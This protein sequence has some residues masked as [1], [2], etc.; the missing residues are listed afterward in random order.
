[1]KQD[2]ILRKITRLLFMGCVI[3]LPSISAMEMHIGLKT[4]LNMG[5]FIIQSTK[6]DTVPPD[7]MKISDIYSNANANQEF[8]A[9][10][11]AGISTQLF[12]SEQQSWFLELDMMYARRNH[13]FPVSYGQKTNLTQKIE[14]SYILIPL[15]LKYDFIESP[16][17]DFFIGIGGYAGYVLSARANVTL[18]NNGT[19]TSWTDDWLAKDLSADTDGTQMQKMDFGATFALGYGMAISEKSPIK[20]SVEGKLFAGISNLSPPD[21]AKKEGNG[22]QLQNMAFSLLLGCHYRI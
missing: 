3:T 6:T 17:Q 9:G 20:I 21:N 13:D 2:T 1:M 5:R 8:K 19:I 14:K 7:N 10:Y 11:D 18:N 12:F 4:G 22:M 16:A 15:T